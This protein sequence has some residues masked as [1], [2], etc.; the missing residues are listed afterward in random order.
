MTPNTVDDRHN[1]I[2]DINIYWHLQ[3]R[4]IVV[5]YCIADMWRLDICLL[6]LC[7]VLAWRST[8][9]DIYTLPPLT[10]Q[11]GMYIGNNTTTPCYL[12]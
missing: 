12:P 8:A 5:Q 7:L 11:T 1:N 2:I 9:A 10:L 6:V 4:Y 3:S